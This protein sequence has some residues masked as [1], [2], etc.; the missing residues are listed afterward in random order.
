MPRS[1]SGKVRLRQWVLG[2]I[3]SRRTDDE[4]ALDKHIAARIRAGRAMRDLPQ[5]GL[6]AKIGVTFQQIQKYETARNR[7][8]A[9][10]LIM[11]ADALG[12]PLSWFFDGIQRG[13]DRDDPE[14]ASVLALSGRISRL[15]ERERRIVMRLVNELER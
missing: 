8:S 10:R 11:I 6:S 7:V 14:L 12:L 4:F 2:E 3:G 9:S 13:P 5:E 15:P 1:S